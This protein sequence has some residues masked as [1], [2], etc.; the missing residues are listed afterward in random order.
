MIKILSKSIF[1]IL[2]FF[3][4]LLKKIFKRSFLIF[5]KEF[6]EAKSYT[7]KKILNK[8]IKFF[9]PNQLISW[10][11]NTLYSKEPETLEW[12][13]N[14]KNDLKFNFW[15]IGAN[16]G[17]YSIYASTKHENISI[18]SFE[19]S[20][21]NLRIL[22]RNIFI[23][24]LEKKIKIFQI[25]LT[26]KENNFQTMKETQFVEGYSMSTFSED[27]SFKGNHVSE[28]KYQIFGTSINYLINNDILEIPDYI[29]IDVDGLEHIILDGGINVISN[30]KVK[31]I[32]IEI[33][34]ENINQ[35][36]EII[37]IM[38]KSNFTLRNK[39]RAEEFYKGSFSRVYNYIFEK[40]A[41]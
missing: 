34:E 9:I 36:N 37:K 41:N 17:L 19:P 14:F 40:N 11:V 5:F 10:R 20:T 21:N 6:L 28:N 27:E 29:K 33:D 8:D 18:T 7:Y 12:I 31:S 23:N 13:D 32:L 3:D 30:K 4:Y 2:Y 16:V 35:Y 25:P 22:S 24:N 38:S 15:D 1:N 26:N 39:K